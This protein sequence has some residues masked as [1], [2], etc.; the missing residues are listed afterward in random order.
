MSKV[1][2][3]GKNNAEATELESR[4]A[5]YHRKTNNLDDDTTIK[6]QFTGVRRNFVGNTLPLLKTLKSIITDS[7]PLNALELILPQK[8]SLAARLIPTATHCRNCRRGVSP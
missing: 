1:L 3:A 4:I 5:F 6:I 2:E 8:K 7:R